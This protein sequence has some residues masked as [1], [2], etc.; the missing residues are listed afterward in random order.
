MVTGNKLLSLF[1][2]LLP[3]SKLRLRDLRTAMQMKVSRKEQRSV[4]LDI[5]AKELNEFLFLPDKYRL[6]NRKLKQ[7]ILSSYWEGHQAQ[8]LQKGE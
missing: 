5:R 2:L 1:I 8:Y 4:I 3:A 7:G 6:Q